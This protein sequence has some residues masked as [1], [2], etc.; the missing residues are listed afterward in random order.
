MQ[1]PALRSV[2]MRQIRGGGG[3]LLR[4]H[5][6]LPCGH[7][8]YREV[9]AEPQSHIC[10]DQIAAGP[11]RPSPQR[12]EGQNEGFGSWSLFSNFRT[13]S[14]QPSPLWGE[15]GA[16]CAVRGGD[17]GHGRQSILLLGCIR[18]SG[19]YS[20]MFNAM[21]RRSRIDRPTARGGAAHSGH[22]DNQA[23]FNTSVTEFRARH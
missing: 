23:A 15:G 5:G 17:Q 21:G 14:P 16:P 3:I 13:P 8:I 12:G 20:P 9:A 4:L 6:N 22:R 18:N 11:L 19:R 10:P 1:R 7:S 2:H